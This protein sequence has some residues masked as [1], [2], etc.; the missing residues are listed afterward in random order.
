MSSWLA[1]FRAAAPPMEVAQAWWDGLS[2]AERRRAE[3]DAGA[4]RAELRQR[5]VAAG[6]TCEEVRS[7]AQK[8]DLVQ[9]GRT[10]IN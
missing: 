8:G 2:D 4:A 1:R 10:R 6:T 5:I 7:D 3:D 9:F